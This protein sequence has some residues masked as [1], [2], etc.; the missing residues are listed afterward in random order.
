MQ[1]NMHRNY[2]NAINSN[3]ADFSSMLKLKDPI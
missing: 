1:P 2:N 3:I